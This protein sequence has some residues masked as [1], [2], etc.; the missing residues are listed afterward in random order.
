MEIIFLMI[1][2]FN[3]TNDSINYIHIYNYQET[4]AMKM[5]NN[6][7]CEKYTKTT[8]FKNRFSKF[9]DNS[10]EVRYKCIGAT[11]LKDF[12]SLVE[13]SKSWEK[14]QMDSVNKDQME[15]QGKFQY[16]PIEQGIKSV[17]A[18]LG[19][20]FY[21]LDTKTKKEYPILTNEKFS[22]KKLKN[23]DKKKVKAKIQF[24][25][26][27][28]NPYEQAPM[29]FNKPMDRSAYELLEIQTD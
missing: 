6:Y 21:I 7:T 25:K 8:F 23:F 2:S 4:I 10:S 20:E 26:I 22:H 1:L 16:K 14:I 28:T 12:Y 19:H 27:E 5:S 15:I 17:Q 24:K 3:K 11:E 29:E 18:Y 13:S 9:L